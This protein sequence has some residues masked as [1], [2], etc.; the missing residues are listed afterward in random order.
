MAANWKDDSHKLSLDI[1]EYL[2]PVKADRL[3]LEQVLRNLVDNAT[4]YSPS[5]TEIHVS[6][7]GEDGDCLVI[8]VKDQGKGISRDEQSKLFQSF[9]RLAET[10]TTKPGLGLGLLVCRRLVEAH[11]GEIW[12]ESE[13]GKG[14]TFW[15]TLPLV[16][17]SS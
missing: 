17:R 12:V 1:A 14:S 16:H 11:G 3:R 6:V 13:L 4:K 9:E 2:P 10:S 15:F 7:R 8:G 5:G